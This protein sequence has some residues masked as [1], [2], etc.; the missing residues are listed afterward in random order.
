MPLTHGLDAP[1]VRRTIQALIDRG[2]VRSRT[3]RGSRAD[4][5]RITLTEGGGE[6]WTAERD[7]PWDRFCVDS[8]WPVEAVDGRWMLSVRSP[9]LETARAF[10]NTAVAIKLYDA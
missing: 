8:S 9:A 10:L 3:E 2:L 7:P 1:G 5:T 4:I 6:L